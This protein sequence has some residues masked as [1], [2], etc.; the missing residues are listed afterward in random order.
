MGEHAVRRTDALALGQ[1]A[2]G[3]IDKGFGDDVIFKD[4]LFAVNVGKKQIERFHALSEPL[5]QVGPFIGLD[6]AGDG[7]KGE[8]LLLELPVFIDS[9]AHAIAFQPVVHSFTAF[10]E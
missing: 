2:F 7:I 9:E 10:Y 5:F 4:V 1:I 8:K 6:D 3:G